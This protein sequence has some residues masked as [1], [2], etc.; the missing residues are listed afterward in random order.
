M[1][2]TSNIVSKHFIIRAQ[3]HTQYSWEVKQQSI[4]EIN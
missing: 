1:L 4:K 3:H 2:H